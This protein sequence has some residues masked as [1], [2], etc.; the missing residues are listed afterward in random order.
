MAWFEWF[1]WLL[2]QCCKV[3]TDG[4]WVYLVAICA[5]WVLV[6]FQKDIRKKWRKKKVEKMLEYIRE[7]LGIKDL[8]YYRKISI[9]R[10]LILKKSNHSETFE[11]LGIFDTRLKT[12]VD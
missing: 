1:R 11:Y 8:L 3:F 9:N 12:F 7:E 5:V 6:L 10:Y 4:Y 2:V